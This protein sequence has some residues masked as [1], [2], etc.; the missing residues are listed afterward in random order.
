MVTDRWMDRGPKK[1][2]T[3]KGTGKPTLSSSHPPSLA[4]GGRRGLTD[5]QG[6]SGAQVDTTLCGV[7]Q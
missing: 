2:G 4:F 7:V 5:R 6:Q 1:V 3:R